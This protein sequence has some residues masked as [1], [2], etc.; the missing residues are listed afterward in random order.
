MRRLTDDEYEVCA[1][2]GQSTEA[3]QAVVMTVAKKKDAPV[4]LEGK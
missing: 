1:K 2:K 3:Q 4:A